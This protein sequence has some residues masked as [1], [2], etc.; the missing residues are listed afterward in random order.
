MGNKVVVKI[1]IGLL[2]I[3]VIALIHWNRKYL[4]EP[5]ATIE[6][7]EGWTELTPK[8]S[9]FHRMGPGN[10]NN[11]KFIS[12]DGHSEAIFRPDDSGGQPTLVLDSANLGTYN[13]FGPR[14]LF[15][16]THAIFDVIPY[17]VFGNSP[18]DMFNLDRFRVLLT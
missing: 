9:I 13:F 1:C 16:I 2:V 14:F 7:V 6:D 15:G 8:E 17:F 12:P 11:R 5:V 10:E 18:G 3:G 4:N